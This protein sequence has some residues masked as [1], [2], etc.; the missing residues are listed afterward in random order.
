MGNTFAKRKIK[1]IKNT[2]PHFRTEGKPAV[3]P[4]SFVMRIMENDSAEKEADRLSKNV[5]AIT[6]M[7]CGKKWAAVSV[8]IFPMCSSTATA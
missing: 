8:R 5:Q 1:P 4:N 2:A 3:L 7:P 6:R